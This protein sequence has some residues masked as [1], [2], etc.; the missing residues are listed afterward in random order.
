MGDIFLLFKKESARYALHK[1]HSNE[2]VEKVVVDFHFKNKINSNQHTRYAAAHNITGA[3]ISYQLKG[4]EYIFVAYIH[5]KKV[6]AEGVIGQQ[7][8]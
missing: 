1:S 5:A 6:C 4:R 8:A 3:I 2:I 7:R